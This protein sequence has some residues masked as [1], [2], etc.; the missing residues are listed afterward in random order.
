MIIFTADSSKSS[1]IT[2]FSYTYR[3]FCDQVSRLFKLPI[4]E[5]GNFTGRIV[6]LF[7]H[8]HSAMTITLKIHL[9]HDFSVIIKIN[10]P[11]KKEQ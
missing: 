7:S 5:K 6:K 10:L 9:M 2:M 8:A 4:T 1:S 11:L 3:L